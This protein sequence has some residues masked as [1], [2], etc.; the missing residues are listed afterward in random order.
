MPERFG[1]TMSYAD[2]AELALTRRCDFC[3]GRLG[4]IIHRYYRMRFCCAAHLRA[5]RQ[6]LTEDTR[7]KIRHLAPRA[8]ADDS[9]LPA[10]I[11]RPQGAPR[12]SI[13]LPGAME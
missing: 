6:R 10:I 3:R 13:A 8:G 5:Y 2:H 9:G 1:L 7:A 4:L 12:P 11:P